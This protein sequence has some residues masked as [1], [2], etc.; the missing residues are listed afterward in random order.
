ML[1]WRMT[2]ASCPTDRGRAIVIQGDA[3]RSPLMTTVGTQH[4]T[5]PVCLN[6]TSITHQ[7][8]RG[9]N[10]E[11]IES[12]RACYSWGSGMAVQFNP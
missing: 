5:I 4:N 6:F 3:D 1:S 2:T 9:L 12:R 7:E 11:E 8:F 10:R